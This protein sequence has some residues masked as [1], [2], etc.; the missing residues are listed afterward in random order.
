MGCCDNCNEG[1]IPVDVCPECGNPVDE[2]GDST[3]ICSYS[4][5]E[6][7]TCGWAPCDGSC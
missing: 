2:D 7:E 6:C 1:S 5:V 4:P 3:M